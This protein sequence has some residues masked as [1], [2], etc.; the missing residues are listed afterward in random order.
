MPKRGRTNARPNFHTE[1]NQ[2]SPAPW[3]IERG[4]PVEI[5]EEQG[6]YLRIIDR[7]QSGW[8]HASL[9]DI[10]AEPPV[11]RGV[12]TDQTT[13]HSEPSQTSP[14]LRSLDPGV[15]VEILRP[16]DQFL[17]VRQAGQEG[18]VALSDVRPA[19]ATDALSNG[20]QSS[21]DINNWFVFQTGLTFIDWFQRDHQRKRAWA[22]RVIAGPRAE[23]GFTKLFNQLKFVFDRPA[24]S[25][26]QFLGLISIVIYETGGA[27]WPM[28]ELVGMNGHPG[29]AYAFDRVPGLKTSYNNGGSN[30]TAGSLFR[31]PEFIAAFGHLPHAEVLNTADPRWD[32]NVF[33]QEFT[34]DPTVETVIREA[35]FY[36]FRGRGFI[37]TTWRSAYK[38]IIRFI[39]NSEDPHPVIQQYRAAWANLEPEV[40]ATRSSNAQWDQLFQDTD[41]VVACAGIRIHNKSAGDYLN[42]SSDRGVLASVDAGSAFNCG[43]R[44]N[45]GTDY[46]NKM[47]DRILQ[48]RDALIA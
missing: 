18:W 29:I 44:V 10:E 45:G 17:L 15:E 35:D 23:E 7:G 20:F 28:S 24:I 37:Q 48:L 1:P 40:V 3:F 14:A 12:V 11:A 39:Q 16:Q 26:E 9:V 36:K 38:E 21:S 8:I 27:I 43:R 46:A 42:L 47:R 4:V 32:G 34:T 41:C 2:D 13:L 6:E 19:T 31:D 22:D 33:P 30:R 5:L 25:L